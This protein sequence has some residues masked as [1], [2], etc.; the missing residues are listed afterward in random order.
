MDSRSSKMLIMSTLVCAMVAFTI[1]SATLLY[2]QESL[3][4]K[5]GQLRSQVDGHAEDV[6]FLMRSDSAR[7]YT[8]MDTQVRT[9]HY[10]KPHAGPTRGCPECAEIYERVKRDG[11]IHA[12]NFSKKTK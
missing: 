11:G 3:H 6:Y 10:A 5:V 4:E 12:S 9:F 2:N 8:I 1:Q 7:L